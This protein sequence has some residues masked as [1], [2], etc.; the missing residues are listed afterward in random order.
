MHFRAHLL[1]RVGHVLRH[2]MGAVQP[3]RAHAQTLLGD[4]GGLLG[5]VLGQSRLNLLQGQ[6]V[7]AQLARVWMRRGS[8]YWTR[9]RVSCTAL[10]S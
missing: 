8:G 3:E 4:R 1:H 10:A 6:Q 9:V 7:I 2:F 5:P